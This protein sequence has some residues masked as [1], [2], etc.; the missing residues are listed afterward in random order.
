MKKNDSLFTKLILILFLGILQVGCLIEEVEQP[1]SIEV[2]S[3]FTSV[4][5]IAAIA[6][7]NT[8]PHH[9]AIGVLHPIGWEFESG[10]F[11]STDPETPSGNII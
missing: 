10:T 1:A 9:G 4:L 3:T 6:E 8:N 2:G 5:N 11:E 7:E